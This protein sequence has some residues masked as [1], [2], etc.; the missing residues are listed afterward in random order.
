MSIRR[1]TI[2][3]L[4][5]LSLTLI[6]GQGCP[7]NGPD[8]GDTGDSGIQEGSDDG[9][10]D[11]T[12]DDDGSSDGD[13]SDEDTA[14]S[15]T[16]AAFDK[17]WNRFNEEYS[18]FSYKGIDWDDVKSRHR[19]NFE[20]DLSADVFAQ[21]IGDMLNELHDWHVWVQ[22]P[23]SDAIGYDGSYE[24]NAPPQLITS[25]TQNNDYYEKI[26]DNVIFHA[27][28]NDNIAHIVV[29][30]LDHTTFQSVSD[31]DIENMFVTYADAAGMIIDIR[32][33]NGGDENN[34]AKIASRL[35]NESFIYGHTRTRNAPTDDNG[36]S[37]PNYDPNVDF[38][39][40]A[41][42]TLEPSTATHYD[43]PVICLIGKKCMSSAE[44]MTLMMK[45]CGATLIG[46]TTRGASGFPKTFT[47]ASNGVMYGVSRWI[48]YTDQ[49]GEPGDVIEDIG[50]APDTGY[51]IPPGEGAGKSYDDTHDYVLEKAIDLLTTG[52]SGDGDGTGS[53]CTN[54]Y[55]CDVDEECIDGTCQPITGNEC[56]DDIDCEA[57]P[58]EGWICIDG[59][60]DLNM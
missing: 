20:E 57:F 53:D 17:L 42:N 29:T 3:F 18:Y 1:L 4:A 7:Q 25:Y 40:P 10:G 38:D 33:N 30:T 35:T 52:D 47:I 26:G 55:D 56:T 46:D 22:A 49:N 15:P 39:P 14:S 11:T 34:A 54:D 12:N 21:R 58:G 31:D 8:T 2:P 60:C 44:W 37:N 6:V 28:L 43:G 45:G 27:W 51:A 50:I 13:S 24:T 23:G 9:S 32:Y 5:L 36:D 16:L 48:A 59:Y 19:S 41:S